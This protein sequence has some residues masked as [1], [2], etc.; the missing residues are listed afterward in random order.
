M[1]TLETSQGNEA[2]KVRN[3]VARYMCGR[4][5]DL[6]CGPSKVTESHKSLQNNCIGV[7]MYGG[8]V[9]CDLGKLD[10]FAD[11]AFDYV[12]SSHALED[13]FYTE[14]VLREWWRLLKPSGYL[15]LYLPL[16][17]KV[18]K[19]LGREDWEKFY[20]NIGEE[21]CNTE[22]KQDFVPAAIDAILERIGYSKLCEE[23]IRVEGAEYSFLRVY[24]KLA[25]VKLDI[26]GLVRP[27]KH[28]R[29]LIVRYGAIGDMVQ[30][31]MV[32]RLVKEQGYHVTVNCTPQGADVIKH[33]PFVDEVA[34]QLE[35][36][37]PNTQLKEYWDE[38]APRY[39]LFINLSGATEQ[40]LLVPDRK[41]YEA[42]AKFDVEHP[43]STELEKFT[44][45]VSGLRKQIGDANYYDA[46]LAK[47]GLAERGLNGELYFSPS[48]EFVANDFRARHNG[49]FVILW[50]LSGSA[51]HKIYPYFQQAV[52]QVL[53]EIPEAL[54]ISVGD[55]LCIP[56]ERAESTRYYPRAGDWAIRQSLIMTK[57]A[58]LVIGSETGILNAAGCF[59]TPKITLLS[60]S[61][62]DNLC[63]YWKNDFCLAP[64]DTFCHPCH[65]LHYVHPVGKGSFCNVCQTTHKEQLSPHSEGI[66]SCPHIT[67]M[68]DAPEGEKQVYPL[69]MA[70][71]F[72]PQR[73][74]DR[75]KEVYTLWKAKRLVEVAT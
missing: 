31:S 39:D 57:Y 58:D 17:R 11:E 44:S 43:E 32:F 38:L 4:G 47:A 8:D 55:Y 74:V 73:I 63:K 19:E 59:D 35:D 15:I 30:A 2:A 56:M 33:N 12:F 49:A 29:A 7:D 18:A 23:E 37:V 45:F 46:H 53:L 52:Q 42:A 69:C 72:H 9:L 6:G 36:F 50:S 60:H 26:T 14:P 28:K 5:L 62:H 64:E 1:W 61:T 10:L 48:E 67:E 16:T 40:T 70:R 75:V 65:M 41:F 68:T 24:Q 13:F 34:I 22:H 21:G 3:A 27:E 66:W 54:V 25:S 20:P 51:Y 71:G